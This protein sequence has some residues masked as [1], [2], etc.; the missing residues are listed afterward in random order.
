[1]ALTKH[2][3]I[4]WEKRVRQGVFWQVGV[5]IRTERR[6]TYINIL[7]HFDGN[8]KGVPKITRG[9]WGKAQFAK[10]QV[11]DEFVK[12]EFDAGCML[13][14]APEHI[15]DDIVFDT[16]HLHKYIKDLFVDAYFKNNYEEIVAGVKHWTTM[17]S[18]LNSVN[19]V[20]AAEDLANELKKEDADAEVTEEMLEKA[21]VKI[22]NK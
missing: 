19:P 7:R 22:L 12:S 6:G 2:E 8:L 5:E 4:E 18:L 15:I 21:Q 20:Q 10:G 3:K 1:M 17:K 9:L 13:R 14:D 11:I 16:G